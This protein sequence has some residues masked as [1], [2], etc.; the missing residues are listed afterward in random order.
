VE[1]GAHELLVS[2]PLSALQNG[3]VRDGQT[4]HGASAN[5]KGETTF[6]LQKMC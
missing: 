5:V 2:S 3:I 6:C 1:G 4:V